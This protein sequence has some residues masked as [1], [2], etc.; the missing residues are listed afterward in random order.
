MKI[1]EVDKLLAKPNETIRQH[2]DRLK[3]QAAILIKL[4]C[5]K[6][7]ELSSDLSVACE[8]HDYGK[9]NKEF[10]K[11]IRYQQQ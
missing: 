1:E 11:R 2:T 7:P 9:I 8:Y 3:E 5:I 10:Q 6:S 4:G